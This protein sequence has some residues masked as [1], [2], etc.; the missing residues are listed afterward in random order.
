MEKKFKHKITGEIITYKDGVIK[1]GT[2]VLD[3]GC[4]PSSEYL[5]KKKTG[6]LLELKLEIALVKFMKRKENGCFCPGVLVSLN[7]SEIGEGKYYQV[8]EEPKKKAMK[9]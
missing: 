1:S 9:Y 5:E 2:F 7:E 3:M 4:E 8:I 6:I